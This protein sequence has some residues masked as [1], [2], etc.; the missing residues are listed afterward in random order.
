MQQRATRATSARFST[1]AT[2]TASRSHERQPCRFDVLPPT[3]PLSVHTLP[4][5][6]RFALPV[7]GAAE[8]QPSR[9]RLR[10][11]CQIFRWSDGPVPARFAIQSPHALSPLWGCYRSSGQRFSLGALGR[12]TDL[13]MGDRSDLKVKRGANVLAAVPWLWVFY[14]GAFAG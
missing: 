5:R 9:C 8:A 13:R 6:A 7:G 10:S 11:Q 12:L 2:P 14:L 3:I 1:T 4:S